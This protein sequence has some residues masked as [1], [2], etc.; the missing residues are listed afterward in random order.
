MV[1]AAAV[2]VRENTASSKRTHGEAP[3]RARAPDRHWKLLGIVDS[4]RSHKD[5]AT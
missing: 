4:A 3:V 2:V 1:I 5:V